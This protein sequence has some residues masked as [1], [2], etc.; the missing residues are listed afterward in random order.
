MVG[1]KEQLLEM[2]PEILQI[3]F[4]LFMQA[5]VPA[6]WLQALKCFYLN[7][8]KHSGLAQQALRPLISETSLWSSGGAISPEVP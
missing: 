5:F 7:C 2:H 3:G 1:E 4:L 8:D 6:A